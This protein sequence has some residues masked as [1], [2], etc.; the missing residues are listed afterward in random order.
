MIGEAE[1]ASA[2]SPLTWPTVGP[3]RPADPKATQRSP[4]AMR[5]LWILNSARPS[6]AA[7]ATIIMNAA[8]QRR[9]V[10]V[11]QY[12]SEPTGFYQLRQVAQIRPQSPE[13]G[14]EQRTKTSAACG[15]ALPKVLVRPN[16]KGCSSLTAK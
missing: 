8:W 6:T 4:S 16:R 12:S 14:R 9:M 7:A 11:L 13:S 15:R 3:L 2:V 1:T 5:A 10:G